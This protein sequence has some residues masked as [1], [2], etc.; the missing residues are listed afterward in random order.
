MTPVN[1]SR[2]DRPQPIRDYLFA[3]LQREY[4]E[5]TANPNADWWSVCARRPFPVHIALNER[6]ETD[7]AHVL[8][9]DPRQT[10]EVPVIDA[11]PSTVE[12]VDELCRRIRRIVDA[13]SACRP[14]H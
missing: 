6:T 9:Y 2:M 14:R 11:H 5:P 3:A 7:E 1:T 8:I 13:N 10:E 4:G 12:E